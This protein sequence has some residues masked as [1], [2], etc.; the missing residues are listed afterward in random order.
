MHKIEIHIHESAPIVG[1]R[2]EAQTGLQALV[3]HLPEIVFEMST[4]F[5]DGAH[6]VH[7]RVESQHRITGIRLAHIF[8]YTSICIWR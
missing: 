5:T 3:R 4:E 7:A 1:T 6:E 2:I 8:F